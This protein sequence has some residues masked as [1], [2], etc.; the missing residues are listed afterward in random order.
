MFIVKVTI[1]KNYSTSIIMSIHVYLLVVSNSF[2]H[3]AEY[4]LA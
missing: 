1:V 2:Y 4:K 3:T